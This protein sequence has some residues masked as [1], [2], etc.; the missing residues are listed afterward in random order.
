MAFHNSLNCS[1]LL[2]H[3]RL[4]RPSTTTENNGT[5]EGPEQNLPLQN[6]SL[7]VVWVELQRWAA[8]L[9]GLQL[10]PT[11]QWEAALLF[12]KTACSLQK[13]KKNPQENYYSFIFLL[14]EK[15]QV[16]VLSNQR[17]PWSKHPHSSLLLFI[18]RSSSSQ[19]NPQRDFIAFL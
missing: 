11:H 12:C 16:P 19:W 6:L 1:T 5:W 4:T 13:R 14:C 10:T 3:L 18:N 9:Y 8:Q 7:P 15:V 17:Q 2:C